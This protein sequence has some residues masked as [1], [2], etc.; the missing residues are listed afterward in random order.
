MIIVRRS[1]TMNEENRRNAE[2]RKI[3]ER[4]NSYEGEGLSEEEVRWLKQQERE[5]EYKRQRELR[6]ENRPFYF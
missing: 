6:K 2:R 3:L 4:L 1:A 5:D